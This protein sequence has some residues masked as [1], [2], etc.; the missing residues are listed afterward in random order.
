MQNFAA[1]PRFSTYLDHSELGVYQAVF[2]NTSNWSRRGSSLRKIHARILSAHRL[3]AKRFLAG[4]KG[5]RNILEEEQTKDNVLVFGGIHRA[6]QRV[7]GSPKL[8][9][10]S[11][12]CLI[13]FRF[14]HDHSSELLTEKSLFQ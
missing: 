6:A 3:D 9:F 2:F 5:I 4:L 7:R 11:Y 10:E 12:A 8:V 13:R 14:G 1:V